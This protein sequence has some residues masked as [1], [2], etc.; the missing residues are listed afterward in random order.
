MNVEHITPQALDTLKAARAL[1]SLEHSNEICASLHLG[2]RREK[3]THIRAEACKESGWLI[4]GDH[5]MNVLN[6]D[7]LA[8]LEAAPQLSAPATHAGVTH[9]H[10]DWYGHETHAF[11]RGTPSGPVG[12]VFYPPNFMGDGYD[13]HDELTS[14]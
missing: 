11:W 9:M 5:D 14:A 4:T 10:V 13:T 6:E 2:Q 7:V 3:L 8:D 12:W 1:V